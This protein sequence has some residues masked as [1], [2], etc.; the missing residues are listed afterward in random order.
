MPEDCPDRQWNSIAH[1]CGVADAW[2][3]QLV[4]EA[5][6]QLAPPAASTR[7]ARRSRT[8]L[9]ALRSMALIGAIGERLIPCSAA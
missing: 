5:L 8:T 3:R 9:A 1:K 2:L 6:G 4:E 7:L